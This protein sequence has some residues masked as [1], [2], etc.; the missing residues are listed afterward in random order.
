MVNKSLPHFSPPRGAIFTVLVLVFLLG[1]GTV[2]A[3]E[4][5]FP[6]RAVYPE[7]PYIETQQ[8][9]E[10]YDKVIIVD[11]RS[12]LEYDVAHINKAYFIPFGKEGFEKE[13]EELRSKEDATP[14]IFYCNGHSCAKS[15]LATRK[16]MS[17]GFLNVFCFD[18]G[19]FEW[20]ANRPEEA[21]VMGVT[22]AL[23][24]KIISAEEFAARKL[25]YPAFLEASKD[26]DTI[27]IDIRD[28]F[29]RELA[30]RLAHIRNIPLD[31][32][33]EMVVSRI[34]TEKRLLFFDAVG[35]QV[36]WL[37]YYLEAY[38]YMD[39]NF[40]DGGVRAIRHDSNAVMPI[41][42]ASETVL[43]NQDNLRQV[44][45]DSV[46]LGVDLKVLVYLMGS[47]KFDSF[48][49][50]H[51]ADVSA[52]LSLSEAV[53]EQAFDRL[54]S[55]EI[56]SYRSMGELLIFS[57]DPQLARQSAKKEAQGEKKESGGD[58]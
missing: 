23:L 36:R 56:L 6:L 38:G 35:K 32:L 40:L 11:I 30:P 3:E 18:A 26:P 46:L 52:D 44:A 27:V 15:Y 14:L 33:L 55:Q 21:T 2:R 28:P 19:I 16:A 25:D 31:N 9:I 41:R 10:D 47:I 43:S 48:A 22:P 1:A 29:Q 20:V 54:A 12:R 42:V 53:L 57:I 49:V 37:Q 45:E 34:W 51:P 24:D 39:Y 5:E 50:V 4:E 8:L 58:G 13:L 17:V 7:V